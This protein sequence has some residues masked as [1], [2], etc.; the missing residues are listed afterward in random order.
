MLEDDKPRSPKLDL[1]SS[2]LLLESKLNAKLFNLH[3]KLSNKSL[4]RCFNDA[5]VLQRL[6]VETEI[7]N[8]QL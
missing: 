6:G 8:L 3:S 5:I 4:E 1:S 2:N 7:S